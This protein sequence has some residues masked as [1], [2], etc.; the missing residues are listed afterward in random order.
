VTQ[1]SVICEKNKHAA[2]MAEGEED[3]ESG[4]EETDDELAAWMHLSQFDPVAADKKR[5]EEEA[6]LQQTIAK[7]KKR[8]VDPILHCEG[9]TDVE[10]IYDTPS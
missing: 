9:E 8:K 6:E 10:D 5:R 7:M 2:E 4:E 1:E 3:E